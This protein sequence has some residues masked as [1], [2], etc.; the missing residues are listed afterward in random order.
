MTDK[1]LCLVGERVKL[2]GTI[3]EQSDMRNNRELP[4]LEVLRNAF[5]LDEATGDLIR[6]N[7]YR[8]HKAE[9]GLSAVEGPE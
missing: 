8:Q 6:Q 4:P 1:S 2:N 5:Y 9:Q 3:R 7:T